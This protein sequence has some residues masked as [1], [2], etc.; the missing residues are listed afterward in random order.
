[1][2]Y[3]SHLDFMALAK[4]A[5]WHGFDAGVLEDETSSLFTLVIFFPDHPV[6]CKI[7]AESLQ[8][9]WRRV[10]LPTEPLIMHQ[11]GAYADFIHNLLFSYFQRTGV[12][13]YPKP[14]VE[15]PTP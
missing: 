4:L 12:L 7:P 6:A 2:A 8:G 10:S 13:F 9:R 11:T 14:S 5:E 3:N 15:S 1:M